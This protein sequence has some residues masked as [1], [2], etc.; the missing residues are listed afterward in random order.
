MSYTIR[1]GVSTRFRIWLYRIFGYQTLEFQNR[2]ITLSRCYS[3]FVILVIIIMEISYIIEVMNLDAHLTKRL[4]ITML[5]YSSTKMIS[6]VLA[7][8]AETFIYVDERVKIYKK[9]VRIKAVF[10]KN[11][12][13]V[14]R[15]TNNKFLI[16]III[17]IT[18]IV[19]TFLS[20]GV[21]NS[22]SAILFKTLLADLM[23][24]QI[25]AEIDTCNL[26]VT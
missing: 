25:L 11:S 22:A 9:I 3:I 13:N 20:F 7:I 8:S 17:K 12:F 2:Y 23:I 6:A 19:L 16:Y 4:K 14:V 5:C 26:Y 10:D 1:D 21:G 24:L 15:R 18:Q